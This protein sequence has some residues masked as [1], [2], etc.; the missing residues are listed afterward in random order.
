MIYVIGAVVVVVVILLFYIISVFNKLKQSA[1]NVD[2]AFSGVETYLEE[3]FD[4][5]TKVISTANE[6]SKR[7][8]EMVTNVTEMRSA[9]TKA[10][11][12]D[13][14]I[15]AGMK[16]ESEMPGLL[17]TLENYPDPVFNESFRQ[18]QRAIMAIE[19]KI[20]AARRNYNS[21]VSIYNKQLVTFPELII[22]RILGFKTM[23]MFEATAHKRDDVD[24]NQLFGRQGHALFGFDVVKHMIRERGTKIA[25]FGCED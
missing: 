2:E 8:I 1:V 11:T 5:L 25:A 9:F 20:S 6:E 3:R 21:N 22:A 7:E 14:K 4:M 16:I 23:K 10:R 17:A 24:M 12:T 19:D 13:E 15:E 18:V